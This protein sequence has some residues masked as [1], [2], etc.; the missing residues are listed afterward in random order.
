M[1]S[2]LSQYH[3][4]ISQRKDIFFSIPISMKIPVLRSKECPIYERCL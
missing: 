3:I 4:F 1:S 2:K